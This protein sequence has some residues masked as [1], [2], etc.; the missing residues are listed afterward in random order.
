MNVSEKTVAAASGI[1][2]RVND[3]TRLV[4]V[5]TS[6]AELARELGVGERKGVAIAINNAVVPRAS[7]P[8]RVFAEGDR[9]LVIRATQ[10]G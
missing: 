5:A 1:T 9:V 4:A 2:I 6:I 3:E 8:T 10:G 7:W